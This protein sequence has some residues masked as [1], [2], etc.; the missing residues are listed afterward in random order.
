MQN[1]ALVDSSGVVV[2]IIVW[3]G[4]AEIWS[5]PDGQTAVAAASGTGTAC[6]GGTYS[7]GAFTAPAPV[8]D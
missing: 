8:G 6:I 4:N 3:D 1:Y 5:P 2:N 7:G